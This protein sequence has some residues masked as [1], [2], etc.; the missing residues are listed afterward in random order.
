MTKDE[1]FAEWKRKLAEGGYERVHRQYIRVVMHDGEC[2]C[3]LE[4]V[5]GCPAFSSGVA[6]E[7]LKMSD[8]DSGAIIWAADALDAETMPDR[9]RLLEA[10]P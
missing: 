9:V 10:I 2:L 3:P 7:V 5:A 8:S 6:S 1:F 4:F